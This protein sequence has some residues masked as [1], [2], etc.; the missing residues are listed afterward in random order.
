MDKRLMAYEFL[1]D[2][3]QRG[4]KFVV[5]QKNNSKPRVIRTL[6]PGDDLVEVTIPRYFRKERP[7]MPRQWIL[8]RI[9]YRIEGVDEEFRL[10]TNLTDPQEANR[11][12]FTY[13]NNARAHQSLD[14]NSPNPREIDPPER[15]KVISIPQVGGL[16]HVYRRVA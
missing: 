16:H 15:G 8:R 1:W 3:E 12:Y 6:G 2:I 11:D 9:T 4:E 5:R 7:D 14:G 10:F 13:Y